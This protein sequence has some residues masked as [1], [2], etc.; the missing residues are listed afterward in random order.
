[1]PS[2]GITVGNAATH[3]SPRVPAARAV[4]PL[5]DL[6]GPS[7]PFEGSLLHRLGV[8]GPARR[9]SAQR[10]QPAA[11]WA[12]RER[13]V[14]RATRRAIGGL[15]VEPEI[16]RCSLRV[17]RDKRGALVDLAQLLEVLE[18]SWPRTAGDKRS[19]PPQPSTTGELRPMGVGASSGAE[20]RERDHCHAVGAPVGVL[21]SVDDD[22]V[23]DAVGQL[24]T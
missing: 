12:G 15:Q 18:D 2:R 20:E 13:E 24:L 19:S 16:V 6:R 9:D 4:W 14:M 5:V 23:H 3:T 1:M 11:C 8:V 17:H 21:A 10:T 7:G 22:R